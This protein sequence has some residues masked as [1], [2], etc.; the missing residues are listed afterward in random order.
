MTPK[1]LQK[2]IPITRPTLE[3]FSAYELY[4]KKSITTGMLTYSATMREFEEK[5]AQYLGVKYVVAVSSCTSG[6]MLAMRGLGLKGEVIM[7]S[8]TFAASGLPVVWNNL[9]PVF[10]DIDPDSFTIDVNKIEALITKKTSAIFATHVFGVPCNVVALKKLAKKHNL[11]LI[12]DAAHAFGSEHNSK[13]VGQF[14]DVEVFSLSPTKVLTAGEGG[15]VTTN[16]KKLA[17]YVRQGRNYGD[18]GFS[19]VPHAGLSARMSELHAAVGVISLKSLN[20]NLK[21]RIS[22]AEYFKKGLMKIEPRLQ[23]QKIPD[24]IKT[25]YKDLSVRIRPDVLGYTR[26][27]L[28]AYFT[29]KGVMTRSYF[30]P[31]LHTFATYAPHKKPNVP[32]TDIVSAEALSLPLYSHITKDDIDYV[33]RAFKEFTHDRKKP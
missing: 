4:F 12:F 6:L 2:T 28:Q 9:T 27:D 31:A 15:L 25:N 30:H 14:G 21:R 19:T 11:K 10:V 17:E 33:L 13:K 29:S 5:V 16:D 24:S 18:D 3:A 32:V 26:E 20:K 8:F 23:F 7:P 1:K 22:Q